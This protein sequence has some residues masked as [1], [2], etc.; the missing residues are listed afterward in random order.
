MTYLRL[1][2]IGSSDNMSSENCEV[3]VQRLQTRFN[4]FS[5]FIA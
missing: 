4:F 1:Q 5:S 3:F 2:N